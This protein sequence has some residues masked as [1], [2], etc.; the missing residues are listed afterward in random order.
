MPLLP[1]SGNLTK[2]YDFEEL[3]QKP[4]GARVGLFVEDESPERD[5]EAIISRIGRD[6]FEILEPTVKDGIRFMEGY[7][8]RDWAVR[9]TKDGELIVDPRESLRVRYLPD[10]PG[11]RDYLDLW[12]NS[13][14]SEKEPIKE[15]T[16]S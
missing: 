16:F 1:M 12:D 3:R 10:S 2:F 4:S 6:T 11:Y 13:E 14:E 7:S 5:S 8:V 9:F 15:K